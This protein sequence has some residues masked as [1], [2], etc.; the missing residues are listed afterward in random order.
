MI[1][2]LTYTVVNAAP[3]NL[4]VP[5]YLF[6]LSISAGTIMVTSGSRLLGWEV[7]QPSQ[8]Q[9][10]YLSL[11][12]LALAALILLFD[13]HQ[14]LRFWHLFNPAN[15]N[16]NS[17][18]AWGAWLLLFFGLVLIF[19]LRPFTFHLSGSAGAEMAATGEGATHRSTLIIMFILS[20]LLAVYPG[21]ELG[22]L[23]GKALLQSEILP[24]YFLTTTFLAGLAVTMLIGPGEGINVKARG[25]MLG[26]IIASLVWIIS[27]TL[28]LAA[29]GQAG[30]LALRTWW[31][32]PFFY[33]G[34]ILLGLILPMGLLLAAKK[35]DIARFKF[36][37]VLV[38][39]GVFCMRYALLTAGNLAVL[40]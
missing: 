10:G 38:L 23:Q 18:M 20:L 12:T 15:F 22:V 9:V 31:S 33:L 1:V 14:P 40:P 3:W 30:G 7:Y 13:L 11:I 16:V 29:G 4:L 39:I 17:P 26:G 34:E 6:F 2:N 36:A 5:I 32:N 27:R 8:R 24:A 21:F 19:S 37:A 25:L 35:P 28:L